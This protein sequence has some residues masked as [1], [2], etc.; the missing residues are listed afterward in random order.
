V[1][2]SED[3]IKV[4][5]MEVHPLSEPSLPMMKTLHLKIPLSSVSQSRLA[6]LKEIIVA[7][8]GFCKILLHFIDGK[9]RET[10]I[11]LADH[12]TVDTSQDFQNQIR[13]L[14]KSPLVSFE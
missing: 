13:D 8:R 7:N 14:F 3:L 9:H 2:L 11:A 6:D 12:Y 1:D 5:G 4:K 10:V